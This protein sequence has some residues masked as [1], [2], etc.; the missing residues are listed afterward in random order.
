[1]QARQ[2]DGSPSTEGAEGGRHDRLRAETLAAARRF[3]NSWVELGAVLVRVRERSAWRAWGFESFEAYC[4]KELHIRQKTAM[5]L[6]ASYGF[7]MR[8][9]PTIVGAPRAMEDGE[10]SSSAPMDESQVVASRQRFPTFE[11]IS[12]LAGAEERGQLAQEDY[13][14]LRERLWGEEASSSRLTR[15]IAERFA[16]P[17]P[18]KPIDFTLRKF[19][20]TAR[21]LAD[22]LRQSDRVPE[23]TLERAELLAHELNAIARSLAE[24]AEDAEALE[25]EAAAG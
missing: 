18:P 20:M 14:A 24:E 17:K 2:M 4:A 9:E 12:V 23:E 22:G 16:E 5:K 21:K 10:E 8:H 15:E 1:M 11:A 6:T 19:A 3:K 25:A 7:L 13:A